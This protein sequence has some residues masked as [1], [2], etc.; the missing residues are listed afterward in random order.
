MQETARDRG[1]VD[2]VK[3]NIWFLAGAVDEYNMRDNS[4]DE[5]IMGSRKWVFYG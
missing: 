3:I 5:D 1:T 2:K 4:T